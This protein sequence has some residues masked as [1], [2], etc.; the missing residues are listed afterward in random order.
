MDTTTVAEQPWKNERGY[1][2]VEDITTDEVSG[3]LTFHGFLK[4]NSVYA[5]QLVHVAGFD[6]YEIEKIEI[7]PRRN[8]NSGMSE[9][10]RNNLIQY[11]TVPESLFPFSKAE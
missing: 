9:E 10:G 7:K 3:N 8:A 5:N 6:D 4:G 1:L 2:L 11:S